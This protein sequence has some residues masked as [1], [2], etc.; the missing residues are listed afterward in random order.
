MYIYHLK[1]NSS[2]NA[3]PVVK[4][5]KH[6]YWVAS[7]CCLSFLCG[8]AAMVSLMIIPRPPSHYSPRYWHSRWSPAPATLLRL[9]V[10]SV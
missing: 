2:D 4:M 3:I 9:P 7:S 6:F 10:L 8:Q 5:S 1:Y